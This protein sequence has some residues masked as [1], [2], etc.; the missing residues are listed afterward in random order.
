MLLQVV[1]EAHPLSG[2]SAE[3][4]WLLPVLPLIGFV[5]NGAISVLGSARLGPHDPDMHAGGH[6]DDTH[7][8]AD[9]DHRPNSVLH[10]VHAKP[11]R[12]LSRET[13]PTS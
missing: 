12:V 2:T 8:G 11:Q 3:W 13:A 9:H 5:I 7:G 10:S 6:H 1:A 4:V